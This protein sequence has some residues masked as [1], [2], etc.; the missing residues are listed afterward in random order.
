MPVRSAS[1]SDQMWL[2]IGEEAVRLAFGEGRVGEQG[3]G[4]R[5]QR[6]A[7]PELLRH[8]GFGGIIEIGL[9]GAGAQHHVEPEPADLRH[10]IEHDRVAALGHDRQLGPGLVRPH[11]EPEEAEAELVADRLAPAARWRPASAQ[12]WC[13][14]SRGAPDSSS[15]PAGS[16]LIA[17]SGPV[18]AMTLP[19]SIDR[20]PA[21]AGQRHQQVAD[22]AGLVIGGRA[23]VGAAID[24]LL[25]LG[26]DPPAVAG[27]SPRG[28]Q[29]ASR[30]PALDAGGRSSRSGARASLR[31]LSSG[32]HRPPAR[33]D[34][35]QSPARR[36]PKA[37][38]AT[39]R[40]VGAQDARAE[41]DRRTACGSARIAARSSSL[42]PP[43]GPIR[44]AAGPGRARSPAR[45]AARL[46]GEEQR[47]LRRPVAQQRLELERLGR[48]SGSAVRSHC[49]AASIACARSR[50]RLTPVDARC[51]G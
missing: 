25:V 44:I 9:D 22:A 10:V 42:K 48:A 36:H 27:F 26:A 28:E 3:G 35:Y 18:S 12:V 43:S 51:G 6:Q 11:A 19:P 39:R 15:W 7:D 24:E 37:I 16:R 38:A 2:R 29:S 5:L 31:P 13:R 32:Q 40:G 21:E 47:A 41:R 45:R 23:M 33:F 30:S 8:V 49:S 50:S 17:P 34:G 20:L 1:V 46:V 4:E 14:C